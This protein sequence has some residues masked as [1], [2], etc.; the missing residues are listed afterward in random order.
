MVHW[1]HRFSIS[2]NRG[3]GI[4][5]ASAFLEHLVGTEVATA[6]RGVVEASVKRDDEDE[7]AAFYG[8]V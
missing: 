3:K 4:D 7:F 1:S 2:S 8:L 6:I 5:M